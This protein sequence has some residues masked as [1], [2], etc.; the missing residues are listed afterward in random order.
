M[1]LFA[2][3]MA[4]MGCDQKPVYEDTR[5]LENPP[6]KP[7]NC[8][9]L[10]ELK[11]ITLKDGSIA[12][13]RIVQFNERAK[14]YVPASWFSDFVNLYRGRKGKGEFKINGGF[15]DKG[16]LQKFAPDI[17][18]VEC[19]GVVHHFVPEKP[20]GTRIR[21]TVGVEIREDLDWAKNISLDSEITNLRITTGPT[22]D[23]KGYSRELY[24]MSTGYSKYKAIVYLPDNL[25]AFLRT[26]MDSDGRTVTSRS[27]VKYVEWL[28]T[29]PAKRDNDRIFTLKVDSE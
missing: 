5:H 19:P 4:L 10:P 9:E 25:I 26:K 13:V 15:I 3:I 1:G 27:L 11:N 18:S 28:K 17:H 29:P 21:P 7:P 24:M 2:S 8:L 22:A 16:F 12:D 20:G 6:P 23:Q 14:L